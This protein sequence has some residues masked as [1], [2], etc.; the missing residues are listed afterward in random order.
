MPATMLPVV[1]GY[2]STYVTEAAS[3][4]MFAHFVSELSIERSHTGILIPCRLDGREQ[5]GTCP[6]CLSPLAVG[7][8]S[9]SL[10]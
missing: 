1:A 6:L 10:R 7:R 4:R 2:P 3:K 9:L 8:C 5:S